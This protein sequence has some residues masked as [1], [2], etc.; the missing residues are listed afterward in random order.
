MFSDTFAGI[1]PGSVPPFLVA[2]AVGAGV[3]F[4]T[5]RALYPSSKE[6]P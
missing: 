2:E 6:A 4:L 1:S 5:A 3:G